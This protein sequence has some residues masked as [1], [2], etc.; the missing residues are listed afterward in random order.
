MT[1]LNGGDPELEDDQFMIKL[2][3]RIADH[4]DLVD[5]DKMN[6]GIAVKVS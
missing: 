4:P 2:T 6:L 1:Y 5:D 3:V